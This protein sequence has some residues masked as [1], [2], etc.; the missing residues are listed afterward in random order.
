MDKSDL[1]AE[2]ENIKKINRFSFAKN[3]TYACGGNAEIAYFPNSVNQTVAV[4]DC[5]TQTGKN[6]ITLGNGSNILASDKGFDGSVLSTKHLS[7]IN[8]TGQDTIFCYAGTKVS[9]LMKFCIDYGLGGVEYL[10]GIP[11][12]FGGL[13]FMNG[14]AGGLYIGE[15][16]VNVLLYN[17]AITNFSNKKCN[18]GY[19]YSIMRDIK[20]IILGVELKIYPQS[21]EKVRENVSTYLDYRKCHP[22]G[23][24]CGCVFKNVGKLSAGKIID[25]CGL[26]GL[27]CGGAYVSPSHANFL[28]SDGG[29]ASDVYK[30]NGM[31]KEK[32]FER[33]GIML[34]EEVVYIGDF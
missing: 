14:G 3:T 26:K 2:I 10:A 32:V 5:L 8:R 7:G 23:A 33:T 4:Y 28:I 12:T 20:C 24:S 34:E 19:K 17:G 27:R 11:A 9:A 29:C 31:V 15:N 25:D 22:K 1:T 16:I 6:F 30:L 21:S 13:A 18:F